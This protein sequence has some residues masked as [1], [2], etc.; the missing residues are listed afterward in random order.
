MKVKHLLIGATAT[1]LL[2]TSAVGVAAQDERPEPQ[3]YFFGELDHDAMENP[4]WL[5]GNYDGL[6]LSLIHI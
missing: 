5:E 4:S 3:I 2:A 6:E 1:A